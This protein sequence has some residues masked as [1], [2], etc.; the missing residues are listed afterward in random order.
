MW[1]LPPDSVDMYDIIR[2]AAFG[3]G[4]MV[5]QAEESKALWKHH[6]HQPRDNAFI[7]I[8]VAIS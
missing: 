2:W 8:P 5:D 3:S 1:L 7:P 4:A 6:Q